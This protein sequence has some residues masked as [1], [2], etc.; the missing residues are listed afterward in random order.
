M[1]RTPAHLT[2]IDLE[3]D[4]IP[5]A[6]SPHLFTHADPTL[7]DPGPTTTVDRLVSELERVGVPATELRHIILTHVH[8]DHAGGAGELVRRYPKVT[9]HVH[10]DAGQYLVDPEGLVASTR[11]TFG[12]AHDRLWGPVH[13]ISADRIRGWLPGDSP[14][15]PGMRAISTPGHI[16]HHLAWLRESDGLL[17]AGDSLGI[18]LHPEGPVHPAT[19]APAINLADWHATLEEIRAIGPEW[20]AVAHFGVHADVSAKADALG[21]ALKELED[22]VRTALSAGRAEAEVERYEADVRASFA[23]FLPSEQVDRYFDVFSGANDWAGAR[24]AVEKGLI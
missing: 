15:V 7:V 4:G 3:F 21:V 23:E 24:R 16:G 5:G 6:I 12:E 20:G 10:E 19:P 2:T 14:K 1:I 18:I 13:P 11:R 8:L 9:V 17:A 22:R